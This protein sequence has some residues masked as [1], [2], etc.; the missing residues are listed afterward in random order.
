MFMRDRH[1]RRAL[2][3]VVWGSRVFGG[4]RIV[5]A[6]VNSLQIGTVARMGGGVT[7]VS[8]L[9]LGLIGIA[10]IV[11]LELF[12]RLFDKFLSGN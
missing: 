8:S 10:W 7:L 6:I 9:A 4:I 2:H 3:V 5:L 12:L 1:E 11:G